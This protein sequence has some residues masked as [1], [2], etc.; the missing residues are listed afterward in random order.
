EDIQGFV[1]PVPEISGPL[2]NEKLAKMCNMQ[3][4]DNEILYELFDDDIE[5]SPV[6]SWYYANLEKY[7]LKSYILP[8]KRFCKNTGKKLVFDLGNV[9]IRYDLMKTMINPYN[10]KKAGLSVVVHKQNG[11]IEKELG[12][13]SEDFVISGNSI[14]NVTKENAKILLINP[15]RGVMER[16]IQ[17]E[18]KTRPNRF[19]TPALSAA[20]EG[21]YYCDM[22]TENGYAFDVTDEIRLPKESDLKR[23]ENILIC[24]SC[25]FTEKEKKRIDKLQKCG[26][27]INDKDLICELTQKG[28]D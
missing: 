1:A 17:G 8:L 9:E 27:K 19:E 5:I 28:E 4:M 15:V 6:R 23:Y 21:T 22:L 18:I 7:I 3:E 25:L 10:I 16:Y 12:F 2:W 26:V 24:K 20:I 13:S 14:E 11:N